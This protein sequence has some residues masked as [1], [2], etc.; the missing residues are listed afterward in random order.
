M[1]K[2]GMRWGTE[3]DTEYGCEQR[4][5]VG[6][7]NAALAHPARAATLVAATQPTR[8]VAL[9]DPSGFQPGCLTRVAPPTRPDAGPVTWTWQLLRARCA[10]PPT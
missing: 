4:K 5:H 2:G 3:Y 9:H 6:A 7:C 8:T 10:P 1:C